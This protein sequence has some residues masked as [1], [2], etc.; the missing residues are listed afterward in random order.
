MNTHPEY[1]HEQTFYPITI[2]QCTGLTIVCKKN[3]TFS[4]YFMIQFYLPDTEKG[5]IFQRSSRNRCQISVQTELHLTRK[6]E[7]LIQFVEINYS[8]IRLLK[9]FL[10]I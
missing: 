8:F 6:S 10:A 1:V 5:I 7:T 2:C 9:T 4:L 3:P